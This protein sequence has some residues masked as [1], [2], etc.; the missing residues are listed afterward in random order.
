M[1]KILIM[2]NFV[3]LVGLVAGVLPTNVTIKMIGY[4]FACFI[5]IHN[6][7]AWVL[8][9]KSKVENETINS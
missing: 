5:L 6:M 2:G 9:E 4:F 3:A 7:V 1:T 8:N